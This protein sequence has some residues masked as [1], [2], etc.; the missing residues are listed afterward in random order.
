MAAKKDTQLL[1]LILNAIDNL[2][3]TVKEAGKNAAEENKRL[4]ESNKQE[5][6]RRT[7]NAK[8]E[9][10]RRTENAKQEQKRQT[11]SH[12]EEEK[13]RTAAS[14]SE[15]KKRENQLKFSEARKLANQKSANKQAEI[16][17]ANSERRRTA[18]VL[19]NEKR[20]TAISKEQGAKRVDDSKTENKLIIEEE[21]SANRIKE[22]EAKKNAAKELATHRSALAERRRVTKKEVDREASI[23]DNLREAWRKVAGEGGALSRRLGR[24]GLAI[25]GLAIVGVLAFTRSLIASM[26]ALAGSA[27]ALAGSLVYAAGALGGTFTAAAA[28]AIPVIGLLIGAFQRLSAIQEA[29]KQSDLAK[30]QAFGDTGAEDTAIDNTNQIADANRALKEAQEGVTEAR[31]EAKKE[32]QEL[33]YK[34]REAELALRGAVLSQA[35]AQRALREA[36]REGDVEGIAQAQLDV[37]STRFDTG[38]SR[39]AL[40]DIRAQRRQGRQQGVNGD[41]DVKNAIKAVA[42][43][44]RNLADAHRTAATAANEQS[45]AESNLGYFLSQLSPAERDLFKQFQ[46]FRERFA[47][48]S[49][50]I[51]DIIIRAFGDGLANVE[52]LLFN[53]RIIQG[54]TELAN[55]V[56]TQIGRIVKVFTSSGFLDFFESTLGESSKNLPIITSMFIALSKALRNIATA[57][58]PVLTEFLKFFL[59]ELQ[60]LVD[61]TSDQNSLTDFFQTGFEHFT[62]WYELIKSVIGLFGELMGASSESALGTLSDLTDTINDAKDALAADDSGARNFFEDAAKS[63]EY[64]GEVVVALGEAFIELSGSEHV[65]AL[66]DILVKALIPGLETGIKMVGTFAIA[67]DWLLDIP[68]VAE[69]LK[70][71]VALAVFGSAF[72]SIHALFKPLY[73]AFKLF[74]KIFGTTIKE[75]LGVGGKSG[76]TK[77]RGEFDDILRLMDRIAVFGKFA[78][79]L[80]IVGL[81]VGAV[82]GTFE[83]LKENFLGITDIISDNLSGVWSEFE[84]ILE[85]LEDTLDDLGIQV[86][87][88]GGGFKGFLHTVGNILNFVG[89][90]IGFVTKLA[91]TFA[92]MQIVQTVLVPLKGFLRFIR[93]ITHFIGQFVQNVKDLING[94]ISFGE[95]M[96]RMAKTTIFFFIDILTNA[97]KTLFDFIKNIGQFLWNALSAGL[98]H[99][100]TGVGEVVVN[101]FIDAIN[102]IIKAMNK[103]IDAYNKLPIGDIGKIDEVE[104]ANFDKKDD[105]DKKYNGAAM[106]GRRRRQRGSGLEESSKEDEKAAKSADKRAKATKKAT[107][108]SIADFKALSKGHGVSRRQ[109]RLTNQL[110]DSLG[111]SARASK[112]AQNLQEALAAAANRSTNRQKAYADSVRNTAK[113]ENRLGNILAK[114]RKARVNSNEVDGRSAKIKGNLSDATRSAMRVQQRYTDATQNG[115]KA[116][117]TYNRLLVNGTKYTDKYEAAT[118]AATKHTRLETAAIRGLSRKMGALNSVLQTTAENSRSMGMVFRDVTNKV[119]KEFAVK[120]LK[121]ELPEVGTMFKQV[122]N[123]SGFAKGGYFGAKGQR[124]PDDRYVKVA[125]GEAFLTGAQQRETNRALAV[126]NAV[127]ATPYDS[128]DT[129]FAKET[130]AHAGTGT[131]NFHAGKDYFSRGGYNGVTG[132]TDFSPTL[133]RKLE[134]LVAATGT[135]IY[136]Q[137]GGRTMAEQAS[138]YQAYLNGTGNLAAAPSPTA[139]HIMG[140]AA[141]ITPGSEV[142]GSAAA[143][144]GLGFTVPGESWHI[145]LL[146]SVGAL[147]SQAGAGGTPGAKSPRIKSP[148]LKGSKGASKKMLQG[149]ADKLTKGANKMF[150][151]KINI[152]GAGPGGLSTVMNIDSFDDINHVYEEHNSANG[153]W[154]GEQLPF[155]VIAALAEAVGMPGITMAQMTIGESNRR[156]GA[157]G[158]DPGGT[159]GLGLW[160]ITTYYNDALIASLGGERQMLNPVKN[161]IAAK[162][163]YDSQG[164]GAWYGDG[165]VTDPNA[166]YTGP[167]PDGSVRGSSR[168]KRNHERGGYALP[169]FDEGGTVPG[170]IGEPRLILAHGG[171]EV[172]PAHDPRKLA[173][174]AKKNSAT[175]PKRK[176]KT[177]LQKQID[178]IRQQI[179]KTQDKIEDAERKSVRDR[180]REQIERFRDDILLAKA[181]DEFTDEIREKNKELREKEKELDEAKSKKKKNQIRKDIAEIN[182]EIKEIKTERSKLRVF[183]GGEYNLDNVQDFML[184]INDRIN[185][186]MRD[187]EE[188]VTDAAF[189]TSQWTYKLKK[190][191][192]GKKVVSRV[193]TATEEAMRAL[194]DLNL[195]FK[196]IAQAIAET[197]RA[198]KRTNKRIRTERRQY[199]R[200]I[201][202]LQADARKEDDKDEREAIRKEIEKLRES[203]QD[204]LEKLRTSLKNTDDKR[205]ELLTRRA[206][207]MANRYEA[208]AAIFEAAISRFDAVMSKIDTKIQIATLK[209]TDE[210]GNL[211]EA[212]KQEVGKLYGKKGDVLQ[213][214][215][216]RIQRELNQARKNKDKERTL[217]LEQALLDNEL[218]LLENSESIKELNEAVD[219]NTDTFTFKSTNWEIF[220]QAIQN[221]NGQVLPSLMEKIPKMATGGYIKNDGLAYLHAAEVVVPANK[222]GNSGPLVDTINFTQPLEIADPVA[223]SNQIGFKLSTLKSNV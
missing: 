180:L 155:N 78:R 6:K 141:D 112:R 69:F 165:S 36:V 216:E 50:P 99:V 220:R 54:F 213:K 27:T 199:N 110:S 163:I 149:Q 21:K 45:A 204:D 214:E 130:R 95:F 111:Q 33:I 187:I 71:T 115:S 28:Q 76:L 142:F 136:V 80:G 86:E 138:L 169:A 41:P 218:A 127:G 178:R 106:L 53:P 196:E 47:K 61:L 192:N 176:T 171:E 8:Q 13:R 132:D 83:A 29:V 85:D 48:V 181:R 206:E 64:I 156:P 125:G 172:I 129:L 67:L 37:D 207:N 174:Y 40:R 147:P 93:A 143:R 186:F 184:L 185:S 38:Q 23:V 49:R 39:R 190:G 203:K 212:G 102:W 157:T 77:F 82:V 173:T 96:K 87:L 215:R 145:Q 153:D 94:E 107:Q 72:G 2:T 120:E 63:M 65:K 201:R 160:M 12:I 44:Q 56:A 81:V 32:L 46:A 58:A 134:Q 162:S 42:D 126:A 1:T 114:N 124:K 137:S 133:G 52:K 161:A 191:R 7:E 19:E 98:E 26:G 217:E 55:V 202:K 75:L 90:L 188:A 22:I 9:G 62:A 31:R 30:K 205:K 121:I 59:E 97:G 57:S 88:T 152:T 103:A 148:K 168:K 25:R 119:L 11:S 209:N 4:T 91:A 150:G 84:G 128:L 189:A 70:W 135:P 105:D 182:S 154:G 109:V 166:H 144:F 167:M 5:E 219:A 35:D 179:E 123:D 151:K 200:E 158:I 164:L 17:K 222:T 193:H 34:E 198:T 51:T 16:E 100:F 60:G 73:S 139:P 159:K 177:A 43:A 117:G 113:A 92:L 10:K 195:E 197:R 211:T 170:R 175:K 101:A 79:V 221:G 14:T 3:P 118:K 194:Y 140:V 74:G 108:F 183:E 18:S 131:G 68:L 15:N 24:L 208:Q 116:Q 210:E 66:A 122:K 104:K 20:A 146:S 89:T 223:V